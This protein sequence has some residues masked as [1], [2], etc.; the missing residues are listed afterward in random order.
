MNYSDAVAYTNSLPIQPAQISCLKNPNTYLF[1]DIDPGTSIVPEWD[2]ICE[3]SVLR[4]TVQVA[5]S[6]GKFLGASIIG[7]ISDKFGR[8]LAFTYGALFYIM[9][10]IITTVSPWYWPFVI[11]R[12]FIG[13]AA[14]GIFYPPF[15]LCKP[16]RNYNKNFY[17]TLFSYSV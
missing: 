5:V 12:V 6:F 7:V 8:K 14:S 9:G 2:L 13:V 3:N 17:F 15:A 16:Y 1:Y 4:T 11:G 10:S